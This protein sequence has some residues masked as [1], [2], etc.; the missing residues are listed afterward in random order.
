[1]T[2]EGMT[3]DAGLSFARFLVNN[4]ATD[5][6]SVALAKEILHPLAASGAG[7]AVRLLQ[8]LEGRTWIPC[9]RPFIRFGAR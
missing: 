1:M 7:R 5:P 4:Y 3:V 6:E 8:E 9:P 2:G